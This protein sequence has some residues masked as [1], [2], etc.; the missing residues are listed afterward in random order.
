MFPK[1]R[2]RRRIG[3]G[4]INNHSA[5]IWSGGRSAAG[6][7]KQSEYGRVILPLTVLNKLDCVLEPTKPKVLEVAG[8]LP[9]SLKNRAPI[10]IHTAV[11]SFYNT[12]KH[13]F[14]TLLADPD[15]VAG[16]PAELHRRV[17]GV[18]P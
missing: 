16:N 10:L 2:R 15:N 13:T 12:S 17:L 14:K 6:V 4:T 3:D 8:K 9:E 5:F 1:G 18:G 7:Y 11:E